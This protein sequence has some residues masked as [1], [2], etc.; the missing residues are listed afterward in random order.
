MERWLA[1]IRLRWPQGVDVVRE[2]AAALTERWGPGD[3]SRANAVAYSA[4]MRLG[5]RA[6]PGVG[7]HALQRFAMGRVR[8]NLDRGREVANATWLDVRERLDR[9]RAR[10]AEGQ[11]HTDLRVPGEVLED[12]CWRYHRI[13]AHLRATG[14]WE[15]RRNERPFD[16]AWFVGDGV[17]GAEEALEG[18]VEARTH[19]VHL[20]FAAWWYRIDAQPRSQRSKRGQRVKDRRWWWAMLEHALDLAEATGLGA[21]RNDPTEAR[22]RLQLRLR[23]ALGLGPW[24]RGWARGRGSYWR[25]V[26]FALPDPDHPAQRDVEEALVLLRPLFEEAIAGL[27]GADDAERRALRGTVIEAQNVRTAIRHFRGEDNEARTQRML[28]LA[29]EVGMRVA[30][31]R[32]RGRT[33]LDELSRTADPSPAQIV[34]M[35]EICRG[36]DTLAEHWAALCEAP[37][38]LEAARLPPRPPARRRVAALVLVAA[39]LALAVWPFLRSDEAP[40]L[41]G[42]GGRPPPAH[43]ELMVE[44]SDGTIVRFVE[45]NPLAVGD[46]LFF[47]LSADREAVVFLR[48][49]GPEGREVIAESA[50][51]PSGT[52][53]QGPG[54]ALY[55]AVERTGA[56]VFEAS[57][58][59]DGACN[60]GLCDRH[61]VKVTP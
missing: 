8:G 4:W 27:D 10:E 26:A 39:V 47:R 30:G 32:D 31:D 49:A 33:L 59:P 58:E 54:G 35:D 19:A 28:A 20:H 44:R 2:E 55:Y 40:G 52:T 46:R 38:Y 15:R 23:V 11:P 51:G 43:L 5:T 29:T 14:R 56:Y 60:P 6:E 61:T 57:A 17:E 7:F 37:P 21:D 45:R 1:Q 3:L 42:G 24:L 9:A 36:D 53:V 18:E 22:Y 13:Q 50:V 12:N 16:E 25:Q 34:A 41:R 48:V